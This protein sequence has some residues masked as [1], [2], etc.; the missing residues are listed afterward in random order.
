ME[1]EPAPDCVSSDDVP[2]I[3]RAVS[4]FSG[5]ASPMHH[6]G[7][8]RGVSH[9]A[10]GARW[11]AAFAERALASRAWSRAAPMSG[12]AGSLELAILA[13][14]R[15]APRPART[16]PRCGLAK[17]A[18]SIWPPLAAG[19]HEVKF[20]GDRAAQRRPFGLRGNR[21]NRHL[22]SACVPQAGTG[23]GTSGGAVREGVGSAV[24]R[25]KLEVRTPDASVLRSRAG[26]VPPIIERSIAGDRLRRRR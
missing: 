17:R 20:V 11:S 6:I 16:P 5:M 3:H 8:N 15:L 21:S 26:L 22:P 12:R 9:A 13:G 1:C 25:G 14:R 10:N 19:D 7:S 23:Q 4:R 18:S 2:V 24:V